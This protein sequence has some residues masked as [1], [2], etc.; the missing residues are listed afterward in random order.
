MEDPKELLG[1]VVDW[2]RADER[3]E[4]VVQTGSRARGNRV[5]EYSD[6][7]IELLG[8]GWRDLAADTSWSE[9]FG[10]VLVSVSSTSEDE[11]DDE[12]EWAGRLVVY[13]HG[14]KI[15]FSL[16]GTDRLARL[17]T[18]LDD[19]YQRGYVV[20]LDKVGAAAR[21][22]APT[23]AA[24]VPPRPTREEFDHA[25]DE[26]W[27]EATQVPVYLA[28]GELWVV[29]FRDNTMKEFLLEML[30]WYAATDPAGPPDTWH[31]GHHMDE[32]LPERIWKAVGETFG[33]FDADDSWRALYATTAL[34]RE[35]SETVAQRCGF[36]ARTAL[37][38]QA[39]AR[40]TEIA[41]AAR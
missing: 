41:D 28:R 7:D 26:F 11:G 17:E 6:L 18:G 20:H 8:P 40:L 25:L 30:E 36:P 38:E 22:P 34:F 32:W 2:A 16:A 5:D 29:K 3:V 14:R 39:T 15:D 4:V 1:A 13:R 27:F 9:A 31:I 21:L 19:L 37:A 12:G 35:V 24:P 33:R 10:P 23:G